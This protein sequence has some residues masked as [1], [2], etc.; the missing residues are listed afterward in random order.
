M[1][2]TKQKFKR[3]FILSF[4][5]S[6]FLMANFVSASNLKAFLVEEKFG[7]RSLL[8]TDGISQYYY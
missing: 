4:L 5:I 3:I 7:F 2:K 6:I 1:D 8:I